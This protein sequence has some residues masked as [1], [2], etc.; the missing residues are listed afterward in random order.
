MGGSE[1]VRHWKGVSFLVVSGAPLWL[2][3][4]APVCC[5]RPFRRS[6]VAFALGGFWAVRASLFFLSLFVGG[7]CWVCDFCVWWWVWVCR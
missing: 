2:F 6:E 4:V 5:V 1:R 7:V 3:L